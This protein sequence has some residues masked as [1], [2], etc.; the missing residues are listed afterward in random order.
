M[1]PLPRRLVD[2][3]VAVAKRY[4]RM[5]VDLREAVPDEPVLFVANHGYGGAFDLNVLAFAAMY[6]LTGQ[7]RRVS[8]LTHQIAWS[9]GLGPVVETFDA[10]PAS[11]RHA[12]EA[13]A[14][15]RHALVFPGGDI[16]GFKTWRRRNEVLFCGRSGFARVA[17]EA[18]VPI[19][20]VVT[21]GAGESLLALADGRRLARAM[22]LDRALRL[23]TFPVTLSVPW[24]LN[25]G[26]V[27]LLPYVPLPTKISTVVLPAMRPGAEETAE[28]FA[29]RVHE[30]M[31]ATLASLTDGRTPL[32]G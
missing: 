32:L 24:G 11:H 10:V 23:K 3:S 20:P 29:A 18:G 17:M 25:V 31:A 28:D 16:D 12:L 14:A 1:L 27:G 5:D 7:S 13:L 22:G 6:R 26:L 15:G 9:V 21:A 19:V 4:H 2:V 8:L 30:L